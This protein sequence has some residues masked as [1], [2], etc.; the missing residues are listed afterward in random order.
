MVKNIITR[1]NGQLETEILLVFVK[2]SRNR[3][4]IEKVFNVMSSPPSFLYSPSN[5]IDLCKTLLI[6]SRESGHKINPSSSY[7]LVVVVVVYIGTLTSHYLCVSLFSR[8]LFE[9]VFSRLFCRF[10]ENKNNYIFL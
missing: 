10:H 1:P 8:G 9:K 2:T 4:G 3:F 7:N 5:L 6:T